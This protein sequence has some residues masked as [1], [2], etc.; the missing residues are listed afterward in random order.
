MI[1]DLLKDEEE[2]EEQW[3]EDYWSGFDV[4]V[5]RLLAETHGMQFEGDIWVPIK[6]LDPVFYRGT[7]GETGFVVLKVGKYVSEYFNRWQ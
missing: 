1:D 6:S 4:N 7:D 5:S 3:F 2:G